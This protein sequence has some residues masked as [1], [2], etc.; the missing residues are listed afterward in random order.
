VPTSPTKAASP[1]DAH[2]WDEE[3]KLALV[4]KAGS[5]LFA[6]GQTTELTKEGFEHLAL[7]LGVPVT[8]I[9]RWDEVLLRVETE[10]GASTVLI[11]VSPLGIHMGKVAVATGVIHEFV[12]NPMGKLQHGDP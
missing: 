4:T 12:E 10:C 6:N 2:G 11:P 9:L 5:L 1:N 7:A 3:R 8:A